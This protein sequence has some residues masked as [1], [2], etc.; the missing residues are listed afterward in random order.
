MLERFD[1]TSRAVVARAREE[2]SALSA[3]KLEAEH[4]M[5]GMSRETGSGAGRALAEAGLD[6]DGLLRAL[7]AEFARSLEAVGVAP[8]TIA[9]AERPLPSTGQPRWGA[10]AVQALRQALSVAK[11]RGDRTV[12]PAHILLGILRAHAGTVPRALEAAGVDRA[13]LVARAESSLDRA[14]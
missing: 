6:H 14:A 2:A 13:A 7:D 11:A 4:L 10:S 12:L 1:K 8:R 5:L 9:L 3:T